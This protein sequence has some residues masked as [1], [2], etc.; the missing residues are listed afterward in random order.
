MCLLTFVG[1]H[2]FNPIENYCSVCDFLYS[3]CKEGEWY[4]RISEEK[5][6]KSREI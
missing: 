5:K 2:I 3:E 6:G 4:G 1:G